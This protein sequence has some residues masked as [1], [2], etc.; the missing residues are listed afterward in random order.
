MLNSEESQADDYLEKEFNEINYNIFLCY[1][2]LGEI[3]KGY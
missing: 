3:K 1:L 2:M